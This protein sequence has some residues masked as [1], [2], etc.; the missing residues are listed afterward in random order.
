[1][2]AESGADMC[3]YRAQ[4]LVVVTLTCWQT[5]LDCLALRG[6]LCLVCMLN[7]KVM[8][9]KQRRPNAPHTYTCNHCLPG[10]WLAAA[11]ALMQLPPRRL[12]HQHVLAGFLGSSTLMSICRCTSSN[13]ASSFWLLA[14]L[15]N[16]THTYSISLVLCLPPMN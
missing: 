8:S 2:T 13:S 9:T 11:G 7:I 16:A 10:R 6:S 12:L 1:M 3:W 15:S 5:H 4:I 14:S